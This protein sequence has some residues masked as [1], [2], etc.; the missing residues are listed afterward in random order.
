MSAGLAPYLG[1]VAV[2]GAVAATWA[3]RL[4]STAR[5]TDTAVFAEPE[6]GVRYL[7]CDMPRCA[8]MT[9]PH[10]PQVDGTWVCSH[11]GDVKG[12]AL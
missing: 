12:D 11:C 2:I 9:H 3:A 6:P 5:T 7:R 1:A 10:R 8:H 4:A